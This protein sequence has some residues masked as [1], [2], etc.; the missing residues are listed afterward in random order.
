MS[1]AW[2]YIALTALGFA[3]GYFC[4]GIAGPIIAF[5]IFLIGFRVGELHEREKQE[6][7]RE[8]LL[9]RACLRPR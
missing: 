7:E 5:C 8:D 6:K 4:A 3:Q 9:R 2:C 1:R